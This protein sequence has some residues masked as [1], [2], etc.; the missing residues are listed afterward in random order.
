MYIDGIDGDVDA[1][2]M[3]VG[4]EAKMVRDI[5]GNKFGK[6]TKCVPC[7]A[8]DSLSL[9]KSERQHVLQ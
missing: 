7:C 1:N 6:H 4:G 8:S 5:H 3:T 2:N 9:R